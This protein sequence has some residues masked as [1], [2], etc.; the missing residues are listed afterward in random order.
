MERRLYEK[1]TPWKTVSQLS[2]HQDSGKCCNISFLKKDHIVQASKNSRLDSLLIRLPTSCSER[3][4]PFCGK[5]SSCALFLKGRQSIQCPTLLN[6][7]LEFGKNTRKY[8]EYVIEKIDHSLLKL[9]YSR[10]MLLAG[11]ANNIL[12][13]GSMEVSDGTSF[14]MIGL[15]AG[16]MPSFVHSRYPNVRR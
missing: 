1:D 12:H 9:K 14:L 2:L 7:L 4:I 13:Y 15:G 10:W 8:E 16:Q 3:Q 11:F 5:T 6:S